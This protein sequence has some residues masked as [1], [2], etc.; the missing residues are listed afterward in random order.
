ME[1]I[2]KLLN[3]AFLAFHEDRLDDAERLYREILSLDDEFA[4]SSAIYMLGFVKAHQGA[5]AESLQIYGD[6]LDAARG[7]GDRDYEAVLLHQIGMVHRLAED[8]AAAEATFEA[9]MTLRHAHLADDALGF[10]AAFYEQGYIAFLGGDHARGVTL[11]N[12]AL[13]YGNQADDPMCRGCALRGLG[14]IAEALGDR[15]QARAH[16]LASA[17]EFHAV[18]E[19]KGAEEVEEKASRLA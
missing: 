13:D 16:F 6:L 10:S 17:S 14:E 11:L 4:A 1:H 9:E 2:E 18:D 7:D 8:Y 3:R 15:E 5:F 19:E 12:T